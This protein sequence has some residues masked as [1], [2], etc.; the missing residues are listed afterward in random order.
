M[1][2][3]IFCSFQAY[4]NMLVLDSSMLVVIRNLSLLGKVSPSSVLID[5]NVCTPKLMMTQI[6]CLI[7]VLQMIHVQP[8]K[9]SKKILTTT[10]WAQSSLVMNCFQQD[11]SCLMLVLESTT[12]LM[13]WIP[14]YRSSKRHILLSAILSP[15]HLNTYTSQTTVLRIRLGLETYQRY[16]GGRSNMFMHCL[17][18]Y[19]KRC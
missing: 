17:L 11:L 16:A 12:L 4:C 10:V 13:R 19:S 7:P 9:T 5:W 1:N 8:L 2:I 15:R 6:K 14:T 3:I 18:Q